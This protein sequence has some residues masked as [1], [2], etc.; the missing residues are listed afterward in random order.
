M[1]HSAPRR[2]SYGSGER[3]DP[4]YQGASRQRPQL[5]RASITEPS[6]TS[7]EGGMRGALAAPLTSRRAADLLSQVVDNAPHPEP[8]ALLAEAKDDGSS[9]KTLDKA[10]E[11]DLN[12]QTHVVVAPHSHHG[13]CYFSFPS[14]DQGDDT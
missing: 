14:L 4:N 9:S 3:R 12:T 13:A 8:A 1:Y 10:E 2:Q 6:L 11:L 5:L 7:C